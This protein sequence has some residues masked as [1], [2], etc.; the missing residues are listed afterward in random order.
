MNCVFPTKHPSSFWFLLQG[1]FWV[2]Q[3]RDSSCLLQGRQG[4]KCPGGQV[5]MWRALPAD[6]GGT[7]ATSTFPHRH[8]L[9]SGHGRGSKTNSGTGGRD[10]TCP[11]AEMNLHCPPQLLISTADTSQQG[12]GKKLPH[13]K[14]WQD[15]WKISLESA[16]KVPK[17]AIAG[18]WWW[19]CVVSVL[20]VW[21]WL[22]RKLWREANSLSA[23]LFQPFLTRVGLGTD[24][25]EHRDCTA[26]AVQVT[27]EYQG[28]KMLLL[29]LSAVFDALRYC[30]VAFDPR[31][32]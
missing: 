8:C 11:P 3:Q 23:W 5:P 22:M 12:W 16:E 26:R 6:S 17:Q 2:L 7:V 31:Q 10:V 18:C 14:P 15:G 30:W 24:G 32:E 25:V 28:S 27:D 9:V 4:K 13:L 1:R 20:Q 29:D 19:G 21:A